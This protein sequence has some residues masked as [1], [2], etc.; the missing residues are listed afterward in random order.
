MCRY[1]PLSAAW[2][3]PARRFWHRFH[4][5]TSPTFSVLPE[6]APAEKQHHH[7]W[8]HW[9]GE[10]AAAP[11]LPE[12]MR[13]RELGAQVYAVQALELACPHMATPSRFWS[14]PSMSSS[15]AP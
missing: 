11:A 13:G 4:R 7:H 8:T 5:P 9:Y 10:V 3:R 2:S 14:G 6:L 12:V 15:P 1:V